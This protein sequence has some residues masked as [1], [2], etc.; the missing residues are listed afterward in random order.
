MIEASLR[1]DLSRLLGV[2]ATAIEAE[3]PLAEL[4]IDSLMSVE[5]EVAVRETLGV[6]LPLGFLVGEKATL[7]HLSQRLA[8]QSQAAIDLINADRGSETSDAVDRTVVA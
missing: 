3:R 6:E 4:G 7:R 8:H 5:L 1:Q 2:R